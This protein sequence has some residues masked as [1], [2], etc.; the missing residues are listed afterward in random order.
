MMRVG[1]CLRQPGS[2]SAGERTVTARAYHQVSKTPQALVASRTTARVTIWLAA[3][4]SG[5]GE[6][7]VSRTRHVAVNPRAAHMR[8]ILLHWFICVYGVQ[9]VRPGSQ[10]TPTEEETTV[11]RENRA[12]IQF[13]MLVVGIYYTY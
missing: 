9:A 11:N 12:V 6:W 7:P 8:L 1:G 13:I 5:R 3:G 2:L 10:G 4:R